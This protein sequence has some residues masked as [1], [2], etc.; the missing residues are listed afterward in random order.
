MSA[1]IRTKTPAPVCQVANGQLPDPRERKHQ[2]RLAWLVAH[3]DLL[4]RLPAAGT[5]LGTRGADALEQALRGMKL[6]RL[7]TPATPS[8]HVRADIR[9]LVAELRA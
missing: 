7:Y 9:A 5:F 3:P 4:K 8:N 6:E 1:A 2:Q